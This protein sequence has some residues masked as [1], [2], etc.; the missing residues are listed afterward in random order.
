MILWLPYVILLY[1][2]MI[3][4][5]L[6][7]NE[8]SMKGLIFFMKW[9]GEGRDAMRGR[10]VTSGKKRERRARQKNDV[11]KTGLVK[12]YFTTLCGDEYYLSHTPK[13]QHIELWEKVG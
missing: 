5:E 10:F 1:V 2:K 9:E 13:K 6:L 11:C 3:P 12:W 4:S 8:T 7:V